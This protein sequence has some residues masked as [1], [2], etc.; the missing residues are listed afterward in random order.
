MSSLV[1]GE[2]H[3]QSTPRKR[4]EREYP[5]IPKDTELEVRVVRCEIRDVDRSKTPWKDYD[6]EVVF[7]FRVEDGEYKNRWLWAE[8]EAYLDD[9]PDCT[10]RLWLQEI[11]GLPELPDGFEFV[12]EDFIDLDCKVRVGTY[13]SKKKQKIENTV[14]DVISKYRESTG[15][16]MDA[17]KIF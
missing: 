5:H 12:P 14:E 13:F 7:A 4:E 16:G 17:E 11:V 8:T 1:M 15:H 2:S 9:S 10:L 6:K 3:R